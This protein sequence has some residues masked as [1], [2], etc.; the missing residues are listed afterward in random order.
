MSTRSRKVT[1]P[2]PVPRLKPF[3]FIFPAGTGQLQPRGSTTC[4]ALPIPVSYSPPVCVQYMKRTETDAPYA[5]VES[6]VGSLF[7]MW[8]RGHFFYYTRRATPRDG[9]CVC[10]RAADLAWCLC[11]HMYIVFNTCTCLASPGAPADECGLWNSCYLL[12]HKAGH[13]VL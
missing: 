1:A 10:A 3:P 13:F 7:L 6:R 9:E 11:V 4:Q 8:F 5:A 12:R 2:D